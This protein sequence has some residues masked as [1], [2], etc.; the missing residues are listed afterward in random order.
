[1][2]KEKGTRRKEYGRGIKRN[3]EKVARSSEKN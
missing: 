1:M 2:E 3:A